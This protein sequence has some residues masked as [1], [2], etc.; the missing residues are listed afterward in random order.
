M[1]EFTEIRDLRHLAWS[2]A[3]RNPS[4]DGAVTTSLLARVASPTLLPTPQMCWPLRM[5]RVTLKRHKD[6]RVQGPSGL[7]Q[8]PFV[9]GNNS[10]GCGGPDFWRGNLWIV[11]TA[12]SFRP[13]LLTPYHSLGQNPTVPLGLRQKPSVRSQDSFLSQPSPHTPREQLTAAH[14]Q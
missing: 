1:G 14:G 5:Q 2:P 6:T 3:R 11:P 10:P 9:T 4:T 13:S 8:A 12:H 7:G